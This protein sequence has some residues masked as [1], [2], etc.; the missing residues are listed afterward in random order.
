MNTKTKTLLK[1]CK[2]A[3][4]ICPKKLGDPMRAFITAARAAQTQASELRLDYAEMQGHEEDQHVRAH[5]EQLDQ[6][7]G[8]IERENRKLMDQAIKVQGLMRQFRQTE[9]RVRAE[10]EAP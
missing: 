1:R 2:D 7:L 8:A 10:L 4:H 5:L 6:K 3:S 9:E